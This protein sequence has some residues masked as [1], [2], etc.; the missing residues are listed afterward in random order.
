MIIRAAGDIGAKRNDLD[1]IFA[2][3]ATVLRE[4]DIAFA[5]LETVITQRG[6]MTPNARLAMRSPP[7]F[8]QSV[9]RAGIDCVSVAGNHCL[10]WGYEGLADTLAHLDRAGVGRCGAGASLGQAWAPWTVEAKGRR[11]AFVAAN[12]ILPEGYAA[13]AD[14]GG[15]APL[16][17][18]TVYQPIEPDQP[19][20][21]ARALSFA[22]RADLARLV[23]TIARANAE[24]DHVV[25][26]LHWGI[27]M[28]KAVL[29]DYQREAAHAA[30][31]AERTPFSAIIR[32][33]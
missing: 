11:V 13:T 12:S 1:S 25:V 7:A 26:S 5:Q 29:A 10:D 28:V 31:E 4:A 30:I 32:I 21:P 14:R 18:H 8:A 16:R 17:A 23:E 6:A 15:C 2:G 33:C 20:T 9:R 3:S 22:D 27:H 19:G 24:A